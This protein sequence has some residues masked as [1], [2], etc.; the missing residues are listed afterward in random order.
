MK[1]IVAIVLLILS[2]IFIL[3]EFLFFEYINP[4]IYIIAILFLPIQYNKVLIIVYG[5]VL[6]LIIDL[7]SVTFQNIGPVHAIS[8]LTLAYF[9]NHFVRIISVRGYNI[10]EFDFKYLNFYR[11]NLYLI[12][13]TFFHHFLLFSFSYLENIFYTFKISLFS[14]FFSITFLMSLYYIFYKKQ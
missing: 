12:S 1:N 10:Q 5:F 11:L 6:G 3:N 9:R 13:A 4:Y 7:G 14:S 8:T 2:Q